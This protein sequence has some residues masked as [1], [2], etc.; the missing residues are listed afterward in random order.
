[1]YTQYI[2]KSLLLQE[3]ARVLW[4]ALYPV[5]A[6]FTCSNDQHAINC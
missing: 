5:N 6:A 1:M 2:T 3:E 4:T